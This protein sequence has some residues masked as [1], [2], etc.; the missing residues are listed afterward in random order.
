MQF[1]ELD[2]W[3]YLTQPASMTKHDRHS[4][5]WFIERYLKDAPGQGYSYAPNDVYAARC[6]LLHTFGSLADAH[7]KDDSVV[8]WRFHLGKEN[9]FVPGLDRM[10]YI[11]VMRFIW[12]AHA[13]TSACLKEVRADGAMNKLFSERLPRVFFYSGVLPSR[14]PAEIAAMEAGIDADIAILDGTVDSDQPIF[15]AGHTF[16][17]GVCWD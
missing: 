14:D 6:G 17:R 1:I 5:M 11:S 16:V 12:D 10:A 2:T 7:E 4:F 9:T 8:L 15:L 3:A 13:A